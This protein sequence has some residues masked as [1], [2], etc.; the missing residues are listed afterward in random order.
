MKQR[1]LTYGNKLIIQIFII[2]YDKIDFT[3]KNSQIIYVQLFEYIIIIADKNQWN[4]LKYTQL[5]YKSIK[6]SEIQE[7]CNRK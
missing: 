7:L 6:K 1:V 3:Y 5:R 2:K 4:S